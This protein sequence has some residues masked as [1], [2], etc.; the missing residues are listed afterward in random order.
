VLN[1]IVSSH[2]Q[3]LRKWTAVGVSLVYSAPKG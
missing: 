1:A 2:A 3:S